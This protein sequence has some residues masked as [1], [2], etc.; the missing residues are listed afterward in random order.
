MNE[1]SRPSRYRRESLTKDEIVTCLEEDCDYFYIVKCRHP[2]AMYQVSFTPITHEDGDGIQIYISTDTESPDEVIVTD[3]GDTWMRLSFST[4]IDNPHVQSGVQRIARMS[5][6][7]CD[8]SLSIK[9]DLNK[10]NLCGAI[11]NLVAVTLRILAYEHWSPEAKS[12]LNWQQAPMY[13]TNSEEYKC[14]IIVMQDPRGWVWQIQSSTSEDGERT[15]LKEFTA[16]IGYP[17]PND[18][19]WAGETALKKYARTHFRK[20]NP[21]CA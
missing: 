10:N 15:I 9:V 14:I 17:T 11:F 21:Q 6:V 3:M 18:A 5:G 19:I 16:A 7:S 12:W 2:Q 13:R 1:E 8:A 20:G 4:D